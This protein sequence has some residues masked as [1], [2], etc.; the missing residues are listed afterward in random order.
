MNKNNL[1]L[2]E[3]NPKL[4]KLSNSEKAVLELLVEAGRLI[5]PIYLE[6]EK[7]AK[8]EIDKK[9]IEE[10]SQKDPAILSPYTALEKVNGEIVATPYH[11]KYAGL[12]KPIAEKLTKASEITDNKEFGKAL[13]IQ[14]KA[15]LDGSYEEATAAF[16]KIESP[17]IF[18]IAIGPVD[19]F[20]DELFFGKASYQAWVGILD[21]DGTERLNNYKSVTLSA[22]R[23]ALMSKGMVEAAII[24]A[25]VLDVVL[26]SGFMARTRFAGV[27]LPTD[28]NTIE[29]YGAQVTLFNQPNDLR[30]KEQIVPTFNKIFS[31]GFKEGFSQE[32]LR[33]G[34]LRSIALHEL[35]HSYLYYKNTAKNL[36]DLF[37]SINELAATVLG[38]RLAGTLLL[39]D[40]IN[41]KQLQ[42]MIV[43]FICR[44]FSLIEGRRNTL[45]LVNYRLGGLIYI[46]FMLQNGALKQLDN[47]VYINFTK[48]FVS[49]HELSSMLENLLAHG[50]RMDAELFIK[51]YTTLY[52]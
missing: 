40:R 2:I 23:H 51:K 21:M 24:R 36:K 8:I 16:L 28:T 17:Y 34:Y 19:H 47:L 35:A 13:K 31:R 52:S 48:V 32:D 25:K 7:Q 33:R 11:K 43:A 26:F 1:P 45:P 39:K 20:D 44:S 50:T 9:E 6:Q 38:L 14:S 22:R 46:N 29:K 15:L 27:N 49:L 30:V 37:P 4:P 10:E 18:D 3:F 41:E 5:V 12:L 42:S